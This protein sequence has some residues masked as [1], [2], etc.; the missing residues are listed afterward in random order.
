ML[1]TRRELGRLALATLPAAGLAAR[2]LSAFGAFADVRPEIPT[3]RPVGACSMG[4][5]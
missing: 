4:A 5:P 1:Y 2:P 3:F